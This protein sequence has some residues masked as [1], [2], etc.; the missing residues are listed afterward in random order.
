MRPAPQELEVVFVA[1]LGDAVVLRPDALVP[2]AGL[3]AL[4][5][6]KLRAQDASSG[7]FSTL[8]GQAAV[9]RLHSLL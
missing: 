9:S 6:L 3:G 8:S 5:M 2:L 4:R 1:G 7:Y